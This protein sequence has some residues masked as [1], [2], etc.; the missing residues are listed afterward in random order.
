ME[1]RKI[2]N[3]FYINIWQT[4]D[5]LEIKA[6]TAKEI[7]EEIKSQLRLKSITKHT[8]DIYLCE[9]PFEK[10]FIME[11]EDGYKILEED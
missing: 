2:V 9:Y 4:R 10:M 8:D 11:T 3:S 5:Q 6:I 7:I 1:E